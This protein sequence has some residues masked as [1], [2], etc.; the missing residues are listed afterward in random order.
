MKINNTD[1]EKCQAPNFE[2]WMD[3]I[4]TE[5]RD[6]DPDYIMEKMREKEEKEVKDGS[7]R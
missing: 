2:D 5:P 7:R 6:P 4:D 3:Y 1:L